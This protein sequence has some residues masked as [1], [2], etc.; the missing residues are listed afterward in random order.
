MLRPSLARVRWSLSSA[1]TAGAVT[2]RVVK[3]WWR[4]RDIM[5]CAPVDQ[6][7]GREVFSLS[8]RLHYLMPLSVNRSIDRKEFDFFFR[9]LGSTRGPPSSE[10]EVF[11]DP[12]V[13]VVAALNLRKVTL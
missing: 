1:L 11:L 5:P 10:R 8:G 6:F 7:A 3:V 13:V 4:R 2:S 12:T 9:C